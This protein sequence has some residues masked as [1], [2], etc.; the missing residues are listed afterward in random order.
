MGVIDLN[1]F[2][3]IPHKI[4]TTY[5]SFYIFAEKH[6]TVSTETHGN[7]IFPHKVRKTTTMG[8]EKELIRFSDVIFQD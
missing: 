7:A 8:I 6:L 1:Q 5:N 4:F 3:H 2:Q